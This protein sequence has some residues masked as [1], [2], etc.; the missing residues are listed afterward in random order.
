M[1]DS[2]FEI[3]RRLLPT[4]PRLIK[5]NHAETFHSKLFSSVSRW[6][7]NLKV[8]LFSNVKIWKFYYSPMW[9]R[10]LLVRCCA[11][12]WDYSDITICNHLL[13]LQRPRNNSCQSPASKALLVATPLFPCMSPGRENCLLLFISNLIFVAWSAATVVAQQLWLKGE[14]RKG[15]EETGWVGSSCNLEHPVL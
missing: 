1:S 14:K 2:F 13:A 9:D 8:L 5:S 6:P 3:Y 7:E 10:F 4:H 12:T 11:A 15:V